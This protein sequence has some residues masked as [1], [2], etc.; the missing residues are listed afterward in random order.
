MPSRA[1]TKDNDAT[2]VVSSSQQGAPSQP[3]LSTASRDS[4]GTAE[5]NKSKSR[6]RKTEEESV[7]AKKTKKE[8]TSN[9]ARPS[10]DLPSVNSSGK[11]TPVPPT[12]LSTKATPSS[13]KAPSSTPKSAV[14]VK[15]DNVS[16]VAQKPKDNAVKKP[17]NA[18]EPSIPTDM[19]KAKKSGDTTPVIQESKG[20]PAQRETRKGEDLY[21]L[22][23]E[24]IALVRNDFVPAAR[25]GM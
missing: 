15:V 9:N 17:V 16:N 13:A 20:E 18:K 19:A 21:E 3:L 25:K 11:S 22:P 10:K 7:S 4:I 5:Q 12:K 8:P 6:K 14:P 2:T 1:L 24:I 23:A